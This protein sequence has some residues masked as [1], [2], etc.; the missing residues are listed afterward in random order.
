MLALPVYIDGGLLYYRKDLLLSAGYDKPPETWID[1]VEISLK[2]QEKERKKNNEFYAFVWQGAQYEGLVCNFIEFA[3]SNNG[4]IFIENNTILINTPENLLAVQFMQ[5]LIH[6]YK[7]SPQNT[8]TEM[9]EEEVRTFFQQGNAVFERNW[10]YAWGLHNNEDSPVKG[11]VGIAPLPHFID[12][13]SVSTLGGW[14]I[15]ISKY[16]DN[17]QASIK[18]IQF[19]TSYDIQK[20]L[21]LELGWNP[22]RKDVYEDTEVLEKNPQFRELKSVFENAMPRPGIPYYTQ[23]SEVIQKN[24][25]ALLS[26]KGDPETVLNDT[27]N[28]I[29]KIIDRYEK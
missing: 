19:I 27:E 18:F 9:K 28:E 29:Q 24:L 14:H 4:G 5:D 20:K 3:G 22:G 23:I 11:K 26:G 16:S 10:P 25:N 17:P 2:I 12:G 6:K 1:L 7:I 15:G 13:K 8:F 21:T